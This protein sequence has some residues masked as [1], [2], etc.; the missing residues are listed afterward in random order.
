MDEV[1]VRTKKIEMD[2]NQKKMEY[3]NY[4]YNEEIT[5]WKKAA[6]A[7]VLNESEEKDLVD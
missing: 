7:R 5:Y 1:E 2:V 4:A 3:I 6:L